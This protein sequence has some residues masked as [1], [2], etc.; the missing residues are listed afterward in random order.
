MKTKRLFRMLAM[1]V[2]ILTML[3]PASIAAAAATEEP[4]A[5]EQTIKAATEKASL[6]T[7]QYGVTSIQYALID[8]GKIV[9][10]GQSGVNDMAGKKPLTANTIYGIGSTSK[11]FTAASVMKLVDAGKLDL[12]R[13][14]VEYIPDFTMKD[15][16]YK[17]ITPRMLL[18][19]SA[20][21]EGSSLSNSFLLSDNDTYAHDTLLKQLADQQLKADPGAFSVYCNDCFSL[22]EILVERVSGVDFTSYIHQSFSKPL[23]LTN[24]GTPL[25]P[26]NESEM[27]ALYYPP[28]RN[29]LP[30]EIVN[31]IGTGGIYSTAEDLVRFSQIFTGQA[32]GILSPASTAAMAEPEYKKGIWPEDSDNIINFGLGWDS[33][34]L[35]PFSEYGISAL[36]KGGDTILYHASLIVLPEHNMAAAVLS[37]GG[38]S[39]LDQLLASDMLLQALQEKGAIDQI[40]GEKSHGKPVKAEIPAQL[41]DESGMYGS[42]NSLIKVDITKDGIMSI[43]TPQA[44]EYPAEK[45]TY[46]EDGSFLSD[47]GSVK[48]NIVKEDNGRTYLWTQ[49]YITI[50]GFSQLALSE[51]AAEKLAPN[52][53]SEEVLAAWKERD[54]KTYYLINEKYTSVTFLLPPVLLI[55]LFQEAPGYVVDRKIIDANA[56]TPDHQIP[57][58]GSRDYTPLRFYQQDGTEYLLTGGALFVSQDALKPL[59]AGK[60]SSVTI[61]ATG[62]AKWY[63]IPD[64]AAGKTIT[65]STSAKGSYAVYDENGTCVDYGIVSPDNTTVLP[66]S[67]TIM[68]AGEAGAKF[69]VTLN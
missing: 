17:Q 48:I 1:M 60:R 10:S 33:V 49:Q 28:F 69:S 67:G 32:K 11:M 55:E 34:S 43:T 56:A 52:E 25:S 54:G 9:V 8:Q 64:K 26:L 6:L 20:G 40:K 19:H 24:T 58:T 7:T 27:A 23:G 29:Q 5:Y 38:S 59:Y 15:E 22:A 47:D 21:F 13:P 63:T 45:Y 39:S 42:T 16:R 50:P 46:S 12:D 68:F 51:Y 31:S 3:A 57:S 36:T 62:Y 37:S 66:A 14:V 53:V 18:N 35:Y 2:L 30:S 41:L 61:P 44:P 65:V 4:Q